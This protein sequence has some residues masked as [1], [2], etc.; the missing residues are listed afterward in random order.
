LRCSTLMSG[1]AKYLAI[2][3]GFVDSP[4]KTAR[5]ESFFFLHFQ[6]RAGVWLARCL[7]H[8]FG[9]HGHERVLDGRC[10]PVV[11]HAGGCAGTGRAVVRCRRYLRADGFQLR[12]T[13]RMKH[14][15][16]KSQFQTYRQK[17][18]HL[19]GAGLAGGFNWWSESRFALP[20]WAGASARNGVRVKGLAFETRPFQTAPAPPC[21]RIT[22]PR[23]KREW[24]KLTAGKPSMKPSMKA[25]RNRSAGS[26]PTA[27]PSP[28]AAAFTF[29]GAFTFWRAARTFQVRIAVQQRRRSPCRPF[30]CPHSKTV[31]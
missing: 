19:H 23:F 27:F 16:F 18:R 20:P 25:F 29:R 24:P 14:R 1:S 22:H 15:F 13:T 31:L 10:C 9:L 12:P 6:P 4:K 7:P 3:S 26:G 2:S 30:L 21:L 5:H 17:Y 11:G 28:S 8:R